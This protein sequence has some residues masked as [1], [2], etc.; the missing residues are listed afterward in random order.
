[1]WKWMMIAAFYTLANDSAAGGP[2]ALP[3]AARTA[4]QIRSAVVTQGRLSFDG[5]ANVGD[6]TGATTT[7]SGELIGGDDITGVRGWVEAPVRTLVTSNGKRDRDLNKSMES[8]RFPTIRFELSGVTVREEAG[9][10]AQVNLRGRFQIHGVVRDVELPATIVLGDDFIGIRADTPLDLKDYR[11][12]GLSKAFG[13]LRMYP[14]ILV[15]ID[16]TFAPRAPAPA[17]ASAPAAE[18]QS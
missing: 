10:T 2:A 18:A 13:V 9:D 12:G 17:A 14:D 16:V 3:S 1:M 8:D 11:I 15:H 5:R 7:V 4:R 6:F